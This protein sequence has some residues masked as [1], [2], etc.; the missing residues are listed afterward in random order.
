MFHRVIDGFMIQGGGMEP[1]MKQKPTRAPIA[2]EAA[3]GL[4]NKRYTV[5]MARTSDPHSATAQFFINVG[6]NDF[7]DHTA[8]SRQGWG[9][10]VFG[11]VI[12]GQDVVDRI[13]GVP[14]GNSGFHQDVPREDVIIERAEEVGVSPTLFLSD[15]HLSPA[16]PALVDAFDAF[17][18]RPRAGRGRALRAGRPVRHLDRRRPAARPASPPASRAH[19]A[20]RRRR[21][22]GRPDDRQSRFPASASGSPTPPARR[23]CPSR[24]VIDL[25][26][27]P[28]LLL[29]GDEL[30]TDDVGYQKY[31]AF[32]R[33]GTASAAFS[34]CRTRCAA[35]SE[36]GC[37]AGAARQLPSSPNR[38][39]TSS[40]RRRGGVARDGVTRMIH[41]HTHRPALHR[42]VVDGRDRERWVLA[43]WYDRG[44][45]LEVDAEGGR[46]REL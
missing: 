3:N 22:P 32:M 29:H 9:Y 16:R 35:A 40:R 4:K 8:P 11:K 46:S 1:G 45:Y 34:R 13:K 6:D 15:L 14:T 23:C 2:N 28:T 41:G 19:C 24:S 10:C 43:D 36:P 37:A 12:D 7:L 27:T 31:R 5:A 30:C 44:S 25:A 21:R 38:S 26:G 33:N 39:W 20:A 42:L 17:L 18:R